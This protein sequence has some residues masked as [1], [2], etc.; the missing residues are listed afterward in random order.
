M[1]LCRWF[2]A[3]VPWLAWPRSFFEAGTIGAL[4]DWFAVVVLFRHPLG[5]PIP[6]TAILPNNK[7]RVAESL[8]HFIETS[9][10][11]EE[12]LGPRFRSLDYAKFASA[13]LRE[14]ASQVASHATAV[15]PKIASGFSD[16]EMSS[17]LSERA[18]EWILKTDFAP[19]AAAGVE[20][21]TA[22]GRDREIFLTVLRATR[23]LIEEHRPTIQS[24]I[25]EEIPL[26]SDLLAGIPAL[27]QFAGPFLEQVRDQLASAVASK[28]IQKIQATL[29][30]AADDPNSTLWH[31]FQNRLQG[32]LRNLKSSPDMALKIRGMQERLVGSGVVEEFSTRVWG[33][34]KDFLLRD[35]E[36]PDSAVRRKIEE[37]I[38]SAAD[39]LVEND[40]LK[41]E[42][43][44]FLGEQVLRSMLA[45][46]P[47]ARELVV[48]TIGKWDAREMADRLEKTVG[49][50]LQFIRINGT[51]VGGCIG[52]L[53]HTGFWLAGK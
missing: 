53:I 44:R 37:A 25:R 39:Q 12:Q 16:D 5:I 18:G 24:K 21:V 28:T 40:T 2:E 13:W 51:L 50:D 22:D 23:T 47:H 10:L 34:L 36:N 43:N 6:H 1:V 49:S 3:E 17:I 20:G 8:A 4:A 19:L 52:L 45:A 42:V 46:R 14:N 29:D 38:Q 26:S 48:S 15:A 32:F 41:A 7:E 33:E 9:F 31:S 11:T 30:E 27:R 35:C